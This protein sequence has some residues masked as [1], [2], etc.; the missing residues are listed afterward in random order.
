MSS[1]IHANQLHELVICPKRIIK[2]PKYYKIEMNNANK[3]FKLISEDEK[4]IFSCFIRYLVKRPLD[5][6]IGLMFEDLML[7][8]VNGFHGATRTGEYV[9]EHHRYPHIHLLSE[10]DIK[11]SR[12]GSPSSINCEVSY[13]DL[14]SALVFFCQSC[15][16]INPEA[17]CHEDA[18][19]QI[20]Y[21]KEKG[22]TL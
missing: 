13:T 7:L 18:V 20:S 12:N 6:S 11:E 8:R 21:L 17:I 9:F 2:P 19:S 4:F 14:S 10:D 5:F 22:G 15:S 16:I 3:R 1:I